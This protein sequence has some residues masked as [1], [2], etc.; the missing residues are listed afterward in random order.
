MRRRT[1][2]G[3]SIGGM[4]VRKGLTPVPET[5]QTE[6]ETFSI[7]TVPEAAYRNAWKTFIFMGLVVCGE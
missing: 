4:L 7:Q 3:F 2:R 6:C 5:Y 1:R